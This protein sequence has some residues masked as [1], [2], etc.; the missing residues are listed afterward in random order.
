[1]SWR[2]SSSPSD[3]IFA[4]LVYLLP[5]L[6]VIGIVGLALM[7]SGSFL[8]PVLSA[9]ALPLSPLLSIYYGF[10]GFMSL[11]IFF[12]IYMLVV[13]NES[14]AHF[15]RFNAMQAILFGIVLSLFS[16]L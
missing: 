10:G 4:C 14:I 9:I 7:S 2:G 15:I 5:L 11:I 13:R 1:M 6:D 3:R 16:L 12:A 8:G